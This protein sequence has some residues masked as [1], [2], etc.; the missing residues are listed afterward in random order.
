ME[1][2]ALIASLQEAH[3]VICKIITLQQNIQQVSNQKAEIEKKAKEMVGL[4]NWEGFLALGIAIYLWISGVAFWFS[5]IVFFILLLII[6]AIDTVTL[7]PKRKLKAQMYIENNMPPIEQ[8]LAELS[9][10]K[11]AIWGTDAAS[12]MLE[13]IPEDYRSPNAVQYFLKAIQNQRA[14]TLKEA[15][16]LFEEYRHQQRME[17]LQQTQI[18]IANQNLKVQEQTRDATRDAAYYSKKAAK[19]AKFGNTLN[20][21]NTVHHWKKK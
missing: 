15:I 12:R 16:N 3:E 21:V 9:E 20:V 1:N 10:E 13:L 5:I 17:N 19:S 14:D 7:E 2:H 4:P 11:D 6:S 8:K 18:N